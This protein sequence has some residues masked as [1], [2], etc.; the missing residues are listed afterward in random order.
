MTLTEQPKVATE[1]IDREQYLVE[2][3]KRLFIAPVHQSKLLLFSIVL[4]ALVVR[5]AITR[6]LWIDEA[7]SVMQGKMPYF[8][9]LSTMRHTD[10]HPPLFPT[11]MWLQERI[12][13]DGEM[14]VR[15]VSLLIGTAVVPLIWVT[16]Q[17]LFDKRTA[18][19]SALAAAFAPSLVWYSQEA[20]MYA[21]FIFFA[22]AT[23]WA[24]ARIMR[25]GSR[26]GWVTY[27]SCTAALLWTQYF[28]I[29]HIA[30]QQFAFIVF[31]WRGVEWGSRGR[32]ARQWLTSS[33]AITVLLAPLV[34]FA[35]DQ[36]GAYGDRDTL[37]AS[38]Q[39]TSEQR[40]YFAMSAINSAVFGYHSESTSMAMNAF[41]P[42]WLLLP[43]ILL[44]R[45]KRPESTL[46]AALCIVPFMILFFVGLERNDVFEL[47]YF[48]G[49]IPALIILIGRY[50][51]SLIKTRRS[52]LVVPCVLTV[53]LAVPLIDQ[54]LADDNSR[55][56]DFRRNLQAVANSQQPDDTLVYEP[57][58]LRPVVSF[59]ALCTKRDFISFD[60]VTKC[61]EQFRSCGRR[62]EP[63]ICR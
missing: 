48:A 33:I 63:R 55:T 62:I 27:S 25:T 29:L 2:E 46:L 36:V 43:L 39:V 41:W 50:C 10:V 17:E 13:G 4:V 15:S 11:L 61:L 14:Q 7:L 45:G 20:R 3:T 12:V 42:L 31:I 58:F 23:I 57:N 47:R 28:S 22:T 49:A 24:Q 53:A 5:V 54:Q 9:M 38:S 52:L 8:E 18:A 51:A 56:Y 26:L 60:G 59:Y 44:G 37:T 19:L 34:W 32:F 30:V 35:L 40:L 6:G 16:A 21:P 1:N